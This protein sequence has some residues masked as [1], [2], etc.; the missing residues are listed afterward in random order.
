MD[1]VVL[2]Q[3]R[4]DADVIDGLAGKVS[5]RV[6]GIDERR[7]QLTVLWSF[8]DKENGQPF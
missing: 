7:T 3:E 4:G 8:P 1:G 2:R 6:G 5:C